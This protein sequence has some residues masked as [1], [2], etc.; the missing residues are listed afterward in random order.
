[1]PVTGLK[2]FG[3]TVKGLQTSLGYGTNKSTVRIDLVEDLQLGD[4]FSPT[5]VGLSASVA[6]GSMTFTGLVQ[7]YVRSDSDNGFSVFQVVLEDPRDILDGAKVIL[8]D[9]LGST[10]NIPNLYNIYGYYEQAAFGSSEINEA[11][12][13]WE[14]IRSALQVLTNSVGDFGNPLIYKGQLYVLDLSN[15]PVP[16]SDYRFSGNDTN[17]LQMIGD[18]CSDIGC[19]FFVQFVYGTNIIRPVIIDRR[20]PFANNLLADYVNNKVLSG[21]CIN[22]SIGI[23]NRNENCSTF[24]LGG[25]QTYTYQVGESLQ[26]FGQDIN[27]IPITAA[28]TNPSDPWTLS[29]TLNALEVRDIISAT[30]YEC[31]ILEMSCASHSKASWL[32]YIANNK[33]AVA[34][35]IGASNQIG[36]ALA[37]FNAQQANL[38]AAWFNLQGDNA[39][40]MADAIAAETYTWKSQRLYEFVLRHHD[41]YVG[42]KYLVPVRFLQQKI[43]PESLQVSYSDNVVSA[44]Y[45]LRTPLGLHAS[46]ASLFGPDNNLYEPFVRY[47]PS[48]KLEV[49][50]ATNTWTFDPANGSPTFQPS[51]FTGFNSQIFAF[52]LAP[53]ASAQG[54]AFTLT[55]SDSTNGVNAC[56][57]IGTGT[58]S[59]IF[60]FSSAENGAA[61]YLCNFVINVNNGDYILTVE[62]A[63]MKD[64]DPDFYNILNTNVITFTLREVA[65]V[66]NLTGLFDLSRVPIENYV[67]DDSSFGAF[68]KASVE[69]KYYYKSSVPYVLVD[70]PNPPHLTPTTGWGPDVNVALQPFGLGG[71]FAD[72]LE[73][74]NHNWA[75]GTM[76]NKVRYLPVAPISFC[77]PMQSNLYCYGP[78]Y[79]AG[80]YGKVTYLKDNSLT[81]WN[82]GGFANMDAIAQ[83]KVLSSISFQQESESGYFTLVGEPIFNMGDVIVGGPTI[84]NLEITAS[85]QGIIT[86]YR[87]NTFTN[88]FGVPSKSAAEKLMRISR[89]GDDLRKEIRRVSND[90][91]QKTVSLRNSGTQFVQQQLV[92][93]LAPGE[94]AHTA[95]TVITFYSDE[96]NVTGERFIQGGIVPMDEAAISWRAN[97]VGLFSNTAS[98][99]LDG[100][101]RPASTAFD[102]VDIAHY[103]EPNINYTRALTSVLLDPF[104]DGN[105]IGVLIKGNDIASFDG[106]NN[107]NGGFGSNA[108]RPVVLRGPLVISGWGYSVDDCYVPNEHVDTLDG[109]MLSGY[110]RKAQHWPTG[111]LEVLWD[112][113]RGVWTGLGHCLGKTQSV[114]G[115]QGGSAKIDLFQAYG[116]KLNERKK[117]RTVYNFF[118]KDIPSNT[119]VISVWVPEAGAWYVVAADCP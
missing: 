84:T 90:V 1:M 104:L 100:L 13:P 87:C 72:A 63:K 45:S 75:A 49:E 59:N 11:G 15:I 32:T 26:Y 7:T 106:N 10:L 65:S 119:N 18:V 77:I 48:N 73:R 109:D 23:E 6:F 55:V 110:L 30:T 67:L 115:K 17:I 69:D 44:G 112:G 116:E 22:S 88:R 21:E 105:D 85:E 20:L 34:N 89:S 16:P 98:C 82:C 40:R 97:D 52:N 8:S 46:F 47:D 64:G 76:S 33:P 61:I 91:I 37:P 118:N 83:A 86:T 96:S 57:V 58:H 5:P 19:D 51:L 108:Q 42:K 2:F 95:A 62:V 35:V 102:P 14:K 24:I 71:G 81:P 74:V 117:D 36:P 68:V 111:P 9:Y 28:R 53:A 107:L 94:R 25:Q 56:S 3:C 78:W 29:A 27:N 41:Q 4:V 113:E 103:T 12:M 31:N 99:S 70:I 66:T 50:T 114:V 92:N 93:G 79:A 80:A 43:E 39:V 54:S 60:Q 38:N 101:F